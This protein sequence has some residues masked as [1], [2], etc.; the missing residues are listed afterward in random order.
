MGPHTPEGSSRVGAAGRMPE[1]HRQVTLMAESAGPGAK[2][3]AG[4][5]GL[6]KNR[7]TPS[8]W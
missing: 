2:S 4:R 5:D 8:S 6:A 7:A 1:E 3:A